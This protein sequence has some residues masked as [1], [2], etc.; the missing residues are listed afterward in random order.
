MAFYFI[1]AFA[2]VTK[3]RLCGNNTPITTHALDDAEATGWV[4][5]ARAIL[6]ALF[7]DNLLLSQVSLHPEV[8]PRNL[9]PLA[10]LAL[11]LRESVRLQQ[12]PHTDMQCFRDPL[13]GGQSDTFSPAG[14]D[15][16]KMTSSNP[17]FLGGHFLAPSAR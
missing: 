4:A 17:S 14:L 3:T 16:L 5:A 2:V 11:R 9:V 10:A 13:N 15:V 12:F 1:S 6:C 8:S 7:P